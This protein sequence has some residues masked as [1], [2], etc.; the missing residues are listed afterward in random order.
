MRRVD[1]LQS[2]LHLRL[3][4]GA[5]EVSFLDSGIFGLNQELQILALFLQRP[6]DVLPFGLAGVSFF[7]YL[8]NF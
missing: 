2:L 1:L 8:N 3:H 6:Q 4:L 7:L 5:L